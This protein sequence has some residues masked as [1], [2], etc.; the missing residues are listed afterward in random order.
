[1]N[2]MWIQNLAMKMP[3]RQVE[4]QSKDGEEAYNKR[5]KIKH[6]TNAT[7]DIQSSRQ[8]QKLLA[9]DQDAGRARHGMRLLSYF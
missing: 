5:Q 2:V 4:Q 6:V 1:M 9:F 8:L 3:K 7:E